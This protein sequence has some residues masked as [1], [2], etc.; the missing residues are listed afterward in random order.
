M[1]LLVEIHGKNETGNE[2]N[3]A[4]CTPN[5]QLSVFIKRPQRAQHLTGTSRACRA[6]PRVS[7]AETPPLSPCCSCSNP[8][9]PLQPQHGQRHPKG[10]R[11]SGLLTK[12]LKGRRG[13]FRISLPNFTRII[14]VFSYLAYRLFKTVNK[15]GEL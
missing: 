10:T 9:P 8:G 6:A 5:M 13:L 14:C 4:S 7:G 1:E 12:T 2:K 11:L 15:I 3:A